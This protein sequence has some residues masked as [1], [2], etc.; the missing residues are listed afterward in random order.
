MPDRELKMIP[1]ETGQVVVE[2]KFVVVMQ[3][4]SPDTSGEVVQRT[5]SERVRPKKMIRITER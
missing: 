1:F 2:Q 4:R 3:H 5:P